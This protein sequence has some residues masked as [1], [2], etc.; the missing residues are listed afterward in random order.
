[1]SVLQNEMLLE[2]IYEEVL[3]EYEQTQSHLLTGDQLREVAL[4]RFECMSN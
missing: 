1:M 3:E 2:Q 4:Y